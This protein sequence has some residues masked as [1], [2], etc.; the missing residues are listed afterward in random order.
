MGPPGMAGMI[1][2][3]ITTPI[4]ATI[5]DLVYWWQADIILSS[6]GSALMALQ[7]SCPWLLGYIAGNQGSGATRSSSNLNAKTTYDFLGTAASS[8]QLSGSGPILSTV[9]C[10]VVFK[11]AS[12]GIFQDFLGGTAANALQLRINSSNQLELVRSGIAA[13]GNSTTTVSLS[14]W[15]QGNVTY[16]ASTGAFAFRMGQAAAGSG[17][18][19]QTISGG[20]P[21][22]CFSPQG[23]TEFLNGALAEI[24]I[25]NRVL[26]AGEIT[27]VEN[28][29]NAKWSV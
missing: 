9:T 4:P 12:V 24:I 15:F 6:S 5:S 11:P 2:G 1:G 18:N 13:I 16:N 27:S 29:L 21:G 25:Y 23:N 26:T 7:N 28:Y 10:F 19:V 3:V 22:I 20:T 17:S 14:T 8:Y